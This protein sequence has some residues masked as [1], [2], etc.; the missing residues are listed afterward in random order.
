MVSMQMDFVWQ[1][2]IFLQ[3]TA[4]R[5]FTVTNETMIPLSAEIVL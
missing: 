1:L 5:T 3:G 4:R 2:K